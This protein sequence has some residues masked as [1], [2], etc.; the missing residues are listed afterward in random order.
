MCVCVYNPKYDMHLSVSYVF[1]VSSDS[2]ILSGV[3]T[4]IIWQMLILTL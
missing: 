2:L 3:F 4:Y 1:F